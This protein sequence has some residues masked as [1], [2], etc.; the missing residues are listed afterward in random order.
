MSTARCAEQY[1]IRI[2]IE[3]EWRELVEF[4]RGSH[5]KSLFDMI[6]L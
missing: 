3:N 5:V 6:G 1:G 2:R 4:Y